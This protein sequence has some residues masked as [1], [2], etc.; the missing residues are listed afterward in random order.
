MNTAEELMDVEECNDER[1]A[2]F[3]NESRLKGG[4]S[5][6]TRAAS[7]GIGPE[8]DAL[9]YY[10]KE[11]RKYPLLT[12]EEEQSLGRRVRKGDPEA[13]ARMIES[14]LRLVIAMGKKY[15]NRGLPFS[16]I[17]E[18]GNLG[19]IRAVEKYQPEKGFKFSTYAAWWIKQAIERAIINQTRVIRL[20]VHIAQQANAYARTVRQLTQELKREPTA[21]EVAKK[22]RVRTGRIEDL[23]QLSQETYSLDMVVGDQEE[24]FKD[25]LADDGVNSPMTA[26]ANGSRRS[27]LDNWLSQLSSNERDVIEMRFGLRT[28]VPQ[29]LKGIGRKYGI[30]RERV[31]QI[32]NQAL[33]KLKQY[34]RSQGMTLEVLL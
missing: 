5:V 10:L 3:S 12:F 30:T 21:K 18:E 34:S 6:K 2:C 31:R 7:A 13:K 20:P 11:V 27:T 15:I 33:N 32:E 22:M 4:Q 24:T 14:N 9:K 25:F 8:P 17:I 28:E 26:V 1:E 29:T 19:L 23:S 16:D